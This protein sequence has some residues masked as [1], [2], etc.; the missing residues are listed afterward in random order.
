MQ[1]G[2]TKMLDVEALDEPQDAGIIQLRNTI[3]PDKSWS[4]KLPH[5]VGKLRLYE[6]GCRIQVASNQGGADRLRET[7]H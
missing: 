4:L 7:D 6:E 3:Q 5:I 1:L 2:P